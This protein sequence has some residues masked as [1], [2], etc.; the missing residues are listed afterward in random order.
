MEDKTVYRCE[1]VFQGDNRVVRSED[2]ICVFKDGFWVDGDYKF[3][4]SNNCRYWIP[5]S[6]ISYIAKDSIAI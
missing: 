1:F 4:Q 6:Q 3:T 2:G 5:P